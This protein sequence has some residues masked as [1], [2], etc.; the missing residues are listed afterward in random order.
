MPYYLFA[1]IGILVIAN[2]YFLLKRSKKSRNVGKD[3]A[4]QRAAT[5]KRHDALIRKLD[6]EQRDAARRVELRN[7]TLEMYDQVRKQAESGVNP[8][9]QIED[10]EHDEE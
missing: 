3:A 5:V 1:V 8:Q 7:K 9:E 10:M 6:Y 4:A 2:L